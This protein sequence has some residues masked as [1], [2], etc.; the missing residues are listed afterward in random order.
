MQLNGQARTVYPNPGAKS[1]FNLSKATFKS[2]GTRGSHE[3]EISQLTPGCMEQSNRRIDAIC[4]ADGLERKGR[5]RSAGETRRA[6][7]WPGRYLSKF[8]PMAET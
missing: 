4:R 2:F 1:T 3:V 8:P 5:K 6:G 7:S